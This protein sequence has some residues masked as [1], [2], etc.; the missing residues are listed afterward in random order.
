MLN[1]ITGLQREA[2]KPSWKTWSANVASTAAQAAL[3]ALTTTGSQKR[4]I[5]SAGWPV[6]ARKSEK[7]R[8]RQRSRPANPIRSIRHMARE[9]ARRAEAEMIRSRR[10]L[11]RKWAGAGRS[12]G[13]I[14]IGSRGGSA[15]YT[16]GCH[17]MRSRTP[18]R[19]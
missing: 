9:T 6:S 18:S 1:P 2:R 16:V 5:A 15:Q 3:Q 13:F 11:P 8:P 12:P 4:S 10:K 19:R 7:A 14:G 17:S